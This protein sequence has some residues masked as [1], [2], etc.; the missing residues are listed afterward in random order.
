MKSKI[1]QAVLSAGTALA[2][3]AA[4]PAAAQTSLE[5]VAERIIVFGDSLSDGGYFQ[6]FLPLPPGEGSFTTNPD[7]VAP[8][9]FAALL[10]YDLK[11]AYLGGGTNYAVG[12]ARIVQPNPLSTLAIP[13]ASQIDNFVA[14]GGTFRPGDI[15]YIQGGGNDYFNFLAG[16][17]IDPTLLTGSATAL[18]GQV[19]RLEGLGAPLIVTM[20]IQSNSPGLDLFNTTYK[21]A[22]AANGSNVLFFDTAMLFDEIVADPGVF[23][24]VN[25]TGTA[26]IGS[27]LTC[28]PEDYV[29]PDAN[30]TY[31]QADD[32]HPAGI[33]Q[34]IQGQ[35]IASL[36]TGFTLPGTIAMDGQRAIRVQRTQIEGAQRNG[37]ASS[38]GLSLF[39][40]AAYD[41]TSDSFPSNFEQD[42]VSGTLGVN[43]AMSDTVGFGLA[44][45]YRSG[46]G[47]LTGRGDIGQMDSD[48]WTISG[49][50]R[51]GFGPVRVMADVTYGQGDTHLKRDIA[52]GP[53]VR[54]QVSD[55]DSDLFGAQASVGFDLLSSPVRLGPE[56]SLSYERVQ[57][58][59]FTE[60]GD[61]STS[62]TLGELEYESVTGRAGFVA[63]APLDSGTGFFMRMSYVREFEDDPLKFT[64]TPRGAPVSFTSS[65][66]NGDTDYAEVAIGLSGSLGGVD[67][68][69]GASA[70]MGRKSRSSLS[71]Y[72]G[73]SVPF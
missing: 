40:N 65:Y 16:G 56:V 69:G 45:G 39:G 59:G 17:G 31:L 30:R 1:L 51:A 15:V 4:V 68:R 49:F 50:A 61:F 5:P 70:E 28:G 14:S 6:Q 55:V 35:A 54:R 63:S 62:L 57:V 52:L 20:S 41:R 21:A 24:I 22:L 42:A 7:P 44:A 66:A 47:T 58:D 18:A 43:Y 53:A 60:G 19:Q 26:C 29:T 71:A 10:G 11:T 73:A 32:V 38:S 25:T 23:G 33:T 2:A 64:V 27:S 46:E 72:L 37:A 36:F 67:L 9:V 12:G 13:V 8:E 48:T 3:F 34:Q